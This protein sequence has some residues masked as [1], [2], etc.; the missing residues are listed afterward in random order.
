MFFLHGIQSL[1]I[2]LCLTKLLTPVAV[3]SCIDNKFAASL[4]WKNPAYPFLI[5]HK[6]LKIV[7]KD[8]ICLVKEI[9]EAF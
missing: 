4:S 2:Y 8:S 1:T 3:R 6:T 9:V 5:D 7:S